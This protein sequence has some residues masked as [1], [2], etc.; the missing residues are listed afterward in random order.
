MARPDFVAAIA[1][2]PRNTF[3]G[4]SVRSLT[5]S[6]RRVLHLVAE[7]RTDA[8]IAAH[9]GCAVST[10]KHRV[11]HLLHK[12][13]CGNR[14]EL[15]VHAVRAG[16]VSAAELSLSDWSVDHLSPFPPTTERDKPILAALAEGR[17]N[18]EIGDELGY[19]EK[20]IKNLVWC[21]LHQYGLTRRTALAVFA[22]LKFQASSEVTGDD[23]SPT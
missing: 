5:T 8:E 21:L 4:L 17:T 22:T 12:S 1:P 3:E 15:A 16:A 7:G 14:T 6:E 18:Q 20:T 2:Q 23:G 19:S 9:V 13:G 10:V 11:S